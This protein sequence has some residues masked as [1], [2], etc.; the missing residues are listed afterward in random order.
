MRYRTPQKTPW[1]F[2]VAVEHTFKL[3]AQI[4][5]TFGQ[6][7]FLGGVLDLQSQELMGDGDRG[8]YGDAVEARRARIYL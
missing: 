7:Q 1:L 5:Q 8:Q 2:Y 4:T 6:R 3:L